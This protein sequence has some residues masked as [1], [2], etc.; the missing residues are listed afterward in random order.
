MGLV[1]FLEVYLCLWP[2]VVIASA[3]YGSLSWF[4]AVSVLVVLVLVVVVVLLASGVSL[5]RLLVIVMT[6]LPN[7]PVCRSAGHSGVV[8]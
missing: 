7:P 2:V 5:G 3:H 1:C 8:A 4:V 6:V